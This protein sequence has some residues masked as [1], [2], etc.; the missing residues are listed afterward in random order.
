MRSFSPI[1]ENTTVVTAT[2]ANEKTRSTRNILN[3]H[4]LV[5]NFSGGEYNEKPDMKILNLKK[6]RPGNIYD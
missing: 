1:M 3:L 5:N 2:E 4:Y 6:P